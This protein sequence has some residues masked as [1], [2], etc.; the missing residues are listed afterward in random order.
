VLNK[1]KILAAHHTLS[2][3]TSDLTIFFD[4]LLKHLSTKFDVEFIWLVY[5]PESLSSNHKTEYN[6]KIID[7]HNINN[8]MELLKLEKPD[9]VFAEPTNSLIDYALS[10]AAKTLL[11]P[12]ISGFYSDIPI[13]RKQTTLIYSYF[14]R[15]FERTVPTDT[16]DS[17][18]KFMKRGRFFLYKYIFLLKTQISIKWNFFKIMHNSIKL[19]YTYITETS[20]LMNPMFSNTLHWVE[21]RL[22]L[23]RLI[24]TGFAQNSL[25]LTGSPHYDAVF[26]NLKNKNFVRNDDK[27]RVLCAPGTLYEHGFWTKQQNELFFITLLEK[28]SKNNK[29]HLTVKIHP[30]TASFEYYKNLTNNV[31]QTITVQQKGNF[32]DYLRN[33]DIVVT[34][35]SSSTAIIYALL[36][37]IPIVIFNPFNMK[38]L[39]I[40]H[41]LAFECKTIEELDSIINNAMFTHPNEE[42]ISKFIDD[43]LYKVDGKSSE[44][45][46]NAMI[47]LL[48]KTSR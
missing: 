40:E 41:N 17:D 18:K 24:E 6:S 3:I 30:S 33:S 23:N 9:I 20:Y 28:L 15:F 21:G 47:S 25:I 43:Y 14:S 46:C 45:I 1:L 48:D 36:M 29:I 42:N 44:R 22:M 38:D 27:I 5:M 10:L 31:D 11:I 4:N 13:P 19:W 32:L 7:I 34:T 39:F 2:T 12:V 35:H 26:D 8:A 16:S 37:R